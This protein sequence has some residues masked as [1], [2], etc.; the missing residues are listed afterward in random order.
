MEKADD[1]IIHSFLFGGLAGHGI[2]TS[3]LHEHDQCAAN[4][5]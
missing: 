2:D 3:I 1:E 5:V 4:V